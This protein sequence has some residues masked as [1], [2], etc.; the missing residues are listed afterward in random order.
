MTMPNTCNDLFILHPSLSLSPLD[1]LVRSE[2]AK[3]MKWNRRVLTFIMP[4]FMAF[5]SRSMLKTECDRELVS[6]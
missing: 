5:D 4:F 3:S 1:C 6:L 2:P